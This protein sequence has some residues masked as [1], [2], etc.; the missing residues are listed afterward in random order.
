MSVR[1]AVLSALFALVTANTSIRRTFSVAN[2]GKAISEAEYM[3][4]IVSRAYVDAR[5]L[6]LPFGGLPHR[7]CDIVCSS[8]H[9][10]M[11]IPRESLNENVAL[12]VQEQHRG[13]F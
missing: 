5:V 12:L 10:Q 1:A 3:R 6:D 11:N 2:D 8:P 4:P 9:G 7:L 13:A